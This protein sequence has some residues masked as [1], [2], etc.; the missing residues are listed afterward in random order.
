MKVLLV[1]ASKHG[2]TLE[3]AERIRT[4][5]EAAT[6]AVD[7]RAPE[8]VE[9]L[10][11]YDAVVCGSAVY[12]GRWLGPA[13]AFVERHRAAL[14]ERPVWLFSSGPIGDP[15]LPPGEPADVAGLRE[16][17]HARD[18]RLFGGRLDKHELSLGEKV[19][20]VGVRAPEGD[21]RPWDE[22]EAWAATIASA[23]L[24]GTPQRAVS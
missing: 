19:V 5:L 6:L 20:V 23:L 10:A 12:V 3:I 1:V 18:H 13:K 4:T 14:L 21:F 17:T 24:A 9:T 8:A 2:A 11:G 22:V 15:P 16:A 7:L